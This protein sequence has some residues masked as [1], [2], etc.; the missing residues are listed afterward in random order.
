M[1]EY[2]GNY[3]KVC[4]GQELGQQI[5]TGLRNFTTA[6]TLCQNVRGHLIQLETEAQQQIAVDLLRNSSKPASWIGWSD[7]DQEENWVSALNSSVSL[8]KENFQSWAPNEPNGETNEN[9]AILG[10]YGKYNQQQSV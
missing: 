6:L 8:G 1:V 2:E 4:R 5:F 3:N 9:C 10:I 7:D